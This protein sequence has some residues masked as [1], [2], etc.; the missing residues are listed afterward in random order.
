MARYKSPIRNTPPRRPSPRSG[1]KA[2]KPSSGA[3]TNDHDDPDLD[4]INLHMHDDSTDEED[5]D[6]TAENRPMKTIR[7]KTPMKDDAKKT[8]IDQPQDDDAATYVSELSFKTSTPPQ[9]RGRSRIS[10]MRHS[11]TVKSRRSPSPYQQSSNGSG[12]GN[13]QFSYNSATQSPSSRPLDLPQ[14]LHA[15]KP[16]LQTPPRSAHKNQVVVP[17]QRSAEMPKPASGKLGT[18]STFMSRRVKER[19]QRKQQ[20]QLMSAS[21]SASIDESMDTNTNSHMN[22]EG[23]AGTV[24]Q[25]RV[26]EIGSRAVAKQM[27]DR[28]MERSP[29]QSYVSNNDPSNISPNP[30]YSKNVVA[31]AVARATGSP[32]RANYYEKSEAPEMP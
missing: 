27:L 16:S 9:Q 29:K 6:H 21:A 23:A 14:M 22:T 3:R 12:G 28:K 5:D 10:M 8:A 7:Q 31:R 30:N 25:K 1:T 15:S 4:H 20:Q 13:Q 11:P 32:M 2:N 18:G 17:S 24:V 26:K 19:K